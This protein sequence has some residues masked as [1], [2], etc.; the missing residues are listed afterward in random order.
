MQTLHTFAITLSVA[1]A[2]TISAQPC[3]WRNAGVSE[4]GV[5]EMPVMRTMTTWD[6]DGPGPAPRL[7]AFGG[8][9]VLQA[10]EL[11]TP[12]YS[13]A[14]RNPA[15]G[16]W[17]PTGASVQALATINAMLTVS[18]VD[19]SET[20]YLAG[21][22]FSYSP[23]QPAVVAW[24][25][26]GTRRPIETWP[27]TPTRPA[28][29]LSGEAKA[30]V[31]WTDGAGVV[32]L[33]AG[34]DFDLRSTTAPNVR[35]NYISHWNGSAWLPMGT[36]PNGA[37]YALATTVD[38]A[39]NRLV[40][41][42]GDFTTIGGVPAPR[43]AVWNGQAWSA[44]GGGV[45]AGGLVPA[46]SSLLVR[47][48]AAGHEL[49]VGG[50]FTS[51]GTGAGSITTS[52]IAAFREGQ[53]HAIGGGLPDGVVDLSEVTLRGG[54]RLA[55][56]T[57]LNNPIQI[58]DGATWSNGGF[59]ALYDVEAVATINDTLYAAGTFHRPGYEKLAILGPLSTCGRCDGIDF[60]RDGVFPDEADVNDFLRVIAGGACGT[61]QGCDTDI[62]NDG[63]SG[64]DADVIAF[65][66][67][68]AGGVCP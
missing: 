43:L 53:W 39:G 28:S 15:T 22:S 14:L 36:A 10:P 3:D 42:G 55:A 32:Q 7:L 56:V 9:F 33:V 54:P 60:N 1:F 57:L 59:S 46:V 27:G 25:V 63:A 4:I 65:F 21:R 35:T 12:E 20:L 66:S 67:V 2:A 48:T 11:P 40:Y 61:S 50:G 6:A 45:S 37:I 29:V 47:P 17:L 30:L 5:L 44:V 18:S 38:A 41:A 64:A 51:V 26:D 23:L 8:S 58:W 52:S 68:L 24:N 31:A 19:G 16:A 62:D 34:G 49:I 13:F